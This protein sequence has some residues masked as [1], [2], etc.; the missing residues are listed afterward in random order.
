MAQAPAIVFGTAGVGAFST[1]QLSEVFD[2]LDKH[3]VK[4]LDTARLYV[5]LPLE[6]QNI[7]DS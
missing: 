4:Q 7:E 3:N 2:I 6:L 5:S 1:E